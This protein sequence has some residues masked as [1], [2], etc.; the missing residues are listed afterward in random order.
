M[1]KHRVTLMGGEFQPPQMQKHRL[2]AL[3]LPTTEKDANRIKNFLGDKEKEGE[4]GASASFNA[5]SSK[6]GPP[7]ETEEGKG[8]EGT[9]LNPNLRTYFHVT[10]EVSEQHFPGPK[11]KL[12]ASRNRRRMGR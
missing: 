12:I 2:H 7:I 1:S 8:W 5:L 4:T 11:F 9:R 3:L 10:R 6:A